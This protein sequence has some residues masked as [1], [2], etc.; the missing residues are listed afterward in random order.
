[1]R[2]DVTPLV[3]FNEIRFGMTRAQVRA[4]LGEPT[5]SRLRNRF[6]VAPYDMYAEGGFFCYYDSQDILDAVEFWDD[7]DVYLFGKGVFSMTYKQLESFV[8]NFS[9]QMT[10]EYDGSK[11]KDLE[12]RAGPKFADQDGDP[13]P[14]ESFL[15]AAPHYTR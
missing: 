8:R 12:L 10:I 7:A 1:M 15:A 4:L 11:A 9:N 14:I 5:K 2:I 3:G 13:E 6:S